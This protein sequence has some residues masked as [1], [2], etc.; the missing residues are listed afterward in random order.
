VFGFVVAPKRAVGL[1][2]LFLYSEGN[3]AEVKAQ[4]HTHAVLVQCAS[5]LSDIAGQFVNQLVEPDRTAKFSQSAGA[6]LTA[7]SVS[8]NK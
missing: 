4:F 6:Q 1:S 5:L 7:V 2:H 3:D 8:K